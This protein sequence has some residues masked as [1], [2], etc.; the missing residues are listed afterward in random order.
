MKQ[1]FDHELYKY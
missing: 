1:C